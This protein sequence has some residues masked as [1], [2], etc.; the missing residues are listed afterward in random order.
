MPNTTSKVTN[1]LKRLNFYRD[2]KNPKPLIDEDGYDVG[3]HTYCNL[4][5]FKDNEPHLFEVRGFNMLNGILQVYAVNWSI[6]AGTCTVN[7]TEDVID[8][9][10]IEIY[11]DNPTLQTLYHG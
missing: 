8:L 5:I 4:V 7:V 1:L 6:A 3:R 11:E 2:V 9:L 10:K